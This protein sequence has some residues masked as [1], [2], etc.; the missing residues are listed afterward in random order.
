MSDHRYRQ[1][2]AMKSIMDRRVCPKCGAGKAG[3]ITKI[4]PCAEDA[5]LGGTVWICKHDG[6]V[7]GVRL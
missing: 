5:A 1:A 2:M 4:S 7:M 6:A 3:A